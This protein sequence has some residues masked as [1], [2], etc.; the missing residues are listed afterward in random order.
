MNNYTLFFLNKE[1]VY[2]EAVFGSESLKLDYNIRIM[3]DFITTYSFCVNFVHSK[4]KIAFRPWSNESR[5]SP[6]SVQHLCSVN[7]GFV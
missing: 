4:Y 5:I 2:K 6:S 1:V 3:E 7:V